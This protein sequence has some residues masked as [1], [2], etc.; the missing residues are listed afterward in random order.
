MREWCPRNF[1]YL[2]GGIFIGI[3][4][5]AFPNHKKGL[6]NKFHITNSLSV[7]LGFN[8]MLIIGQH[9]LLIG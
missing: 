3:K 4:Y 7:F 5:N 8:S 6:V 9:I 1:P 2:L